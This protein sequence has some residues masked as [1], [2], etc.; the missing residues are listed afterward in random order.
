MEL[1]RISDANILDTKTVKKL[2][3]LVEELE[4]G[5]THR[6]R[7][8]PRFLME[9][10]VLNDMKFPTTDAKYWQCNLERDTHFRNLLFA[11][12]DYRE[13]IADIKILEAE[14]HGL[15]YE[16]SLLDG[17]SPAHER[18]LFQ[19]KIVKKNA[20]IDKENNTL[21]YTKKEAYER[22]REIL[23]WTDIMKQLKP[24]LKY[25]KDNVEEH[26]PESYALRF[27]REREAMRI[28]GTENAAHD[29]SGAMNII[30]LSKSMF[31]HPTVIA[32]MEEEQKAKQLEEGKRK[33]KL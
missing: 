6:Q 25:S 22:V 29:L 33:H 18:E 24:D 2:N 8:R 16:L 13:K 30:S 15:Q 14:L 31:S 11:S 20:Q 12:Y 21:I 5:F 17:N 27:A 28:A 7:F 19:A 10:S 32:L 23:N 1:A 4:A 3:E 9:T 26:M